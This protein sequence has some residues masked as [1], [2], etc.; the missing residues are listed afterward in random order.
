MGTKKLTVF[1]FHFDGPTQFG[2]SF[3]EDPEPDVE[4]T[5]GGTD[6]TDAD[7]AASESTTGG[8]DGPGV[9]GVVLGLLVVA[10]VALVLRKVLGGDSTATDDPEM[11]DLD[12]ADW[13]DEPA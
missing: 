12:E 8:G 7:L 2:P 3:G 11:V 9:A 13:D 4:G 1:E 6:S 10:I 5:D